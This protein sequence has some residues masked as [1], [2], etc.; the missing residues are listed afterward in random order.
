M[1]P[2]VLVKITA[3]ITTSIVSVFAFSGLPMLS[4]AAEGQE[5]SVLIEST[6]TGDVDPSAAITVEDLDIPVDQLKLLVKPLTLEELQ[7]ESAAWLLIL[8][9]KVQEISNVEIDIKRERQIIQEEEEAA[10]AVEEAKTKL[11]EAKKVLA[12]TTPGTP[13]YEQAAKQIEKAKQ[14][15]QE[16]ER[17]IE[18][19]LDTDKELQEDDELQAALEEGKRKEKIANARQILE[20]AKKSREKLTAGSADYHTATEKI[21]ILERALID[22][23]AVEE[24]LEGAIPNSPEYQELSK[25]LEEARNK[26]IQAAEAISSS[27]LAPSATD[28]NASLDSSNSEASL[29]N[30]LSELKTAEEQANTE[31][32][33]ASDETSENSEEQLEKLAD[34]TDE[35]TEAQPELKNQLVVNVT[36]LQ[37]EQTEIIDRFNV[38]LD[39]LDNKG[40]DTVSYRKYIDAVSAVELDVKDTEGLEVR[41]I[42][43]LKSEEGGVRWGIN[44]SKFLAILLI[45]AIAAQV[46][47]KA[48]SRIL[49]RVG[50]TSSILRDFVEMTVKQGVLV[51][52]ALVALTSLGVSLGP[53]LALLGGA[54]FVLAFALQ[55][56][57]G[58]FASGLMLMVNKPFDVGDEVKIGETWAWI[59]SIN[60]ANTKLTGWNGEEIIIPNNNVWS[61][62]ISNLTAKDTRKGGFDLYF[63]FDEDIPLACEI[64][65]EV[66]QKNPLVLETPAPSTF[67]WEPGEYG[68]YTS[69]KFSTKTPD[70]WTASEQILCEFLAEFK[71]RGIKLAI[72]TQDIRS[73]PEELMSKGNGNGKGGI[74]L[75]KTGTSS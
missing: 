66:A 62:E 27:Q 43:W 75:E 71:Q 36:D 56:N 60:L 2:L 10:K 8:K 40:G 54:S 61:S 5:E 25:T 55:S 19:A 9:N 15:V 21:D 64:L 58:N 13:E 3:L 44:L 1:R 46:L 69:F 17:D 65:K 32:G 23:E 47:S 18:K 7:V 41:L 50:G 28:D 4:Q 68:I 11:A 26:V 49:T 53:V 72:P 59:D 38:V 16:A 12:E 37:G 33:N 51:V 35:L 45:S 42:N 57:L 52:G 73:I 67:I 34:E 6:F 14:A 63:A 24:E 22:L 74:L 29:E 48:V 31:A 30:L 20:E 70:F 39:G